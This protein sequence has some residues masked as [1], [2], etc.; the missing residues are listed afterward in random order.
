[1]LAASATHLPTAAVALLVLLSMRL[2][3]SIFAR[4]PQAFTK[5]TLIAG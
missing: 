1:M 4:F 2:A 5:L 3:N